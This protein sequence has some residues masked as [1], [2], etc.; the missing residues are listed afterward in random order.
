MTARS[1]A[2]GLPVPLLVSAVL[3][4]TA[5]GVGAA[6]LPEGAEPDDTVRA[7]RLDSVGSG[8]VRLDGLLDEPFWVEADAVTDLRQRE[9][10]QGE[11]ASEG[12]EVRVVYD[13]ERLYVGVRALDSRPDGIVARILQRDRLMEKRFGPEPEFA[14]DDAVA[15]LFDPFHDHRNGVILATNPNGA[16]FDALITDEGRELNM[17]WRGVW[18]VRAARTAE[19]WSAEFAIP[20]RTLRYPDAGE[21]RP[22]G[23]NVYRVIRRTNELVL[24]QSWT[25]EGGGFARV[26]RAGHL[27]GLE[28]LPRAGL[29]LEAKPFLLTGTRQRRTDGGQL[30]V[31]GE[32]DAGLDLKAEPMP[33]LVVDLTLNTD[34]AQVEVDEVQVNLTRFSLFYP[35]KRDFFL[36]NA[37]IFEFGIAGDPMEPPPILLFFSRRIGLVAGHE[38]PILGGARVTGRAG[39]QTL[40]FLNLV[41]D[42]APNAP[43]TN[44]GVVRVKRDVGS[45]NY[46]GWMLTDRRSMDAWNTT[47]GV[48]GSFWL[49]ERLNLQGFWAG[50]RTS[51]AG[52]DDHAYRLVLRSDGNRAG[53]EVQHFAIGPEMRAGMG[54]ITRTGIRRT[55]GFLRLTLRPRALGLRKIDVFTSGE[56]VMNTGGR[57]LDWRGGNYLSHEWN[58]GDRFTL[59]YQKAEIEVQEEFRLA[60]TLPVPAG[61]YDNSFLGWFGN[62]SRARPV[63]LES[64][65]RIQRAYGGWIA[66]LGGTLT[67][68]P[69]ARAAVALGFTRNRAEI[70]SGEFTAD[71]SSLRVSYYF[72]TR[73]TADL[74][75]QYNSLTRDMITNFRFNLIHRPGSDLFLVLTETRG[76][77]ESL[78][79]VQDRGVVAKLT[80]LA[81]L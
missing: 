37:G 81:R 36:E 14:G 61:R 12:T 77:L 57:V 31:D 10:R 20:F 34:F 69:S 29:N 44:F 33:G 55:D 78:W 53:F 66:S 80:Y 64:R 28:A 15:L 17:G 67:V 62:T 18:E 79:P 13:D 6:A 1:A 39:A 16:E 74:F 19:G 47:A 51:G 43:R 73:A 11:P 48:D 30:P 22:W 40:G 7:Y 41:T 24:W 4:A 45:N 49:S 50:S 21:G 42:A 32:V 35:E 65:S 68:R 9:P 54:F 76:D 71:I 26:S 59:F 3:V 56:L 38:I 72:S 46:L 70:P 8:R 27:A 2:F 23:F 25:R 60:D 58:T 5:A 75:V 63:F 52:G